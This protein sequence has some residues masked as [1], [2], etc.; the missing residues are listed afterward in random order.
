MNPSLLAQNAYA[1]RVAP[2][3]T[4][5]GVE[6]DAF[7]KITSALKSAAD[8]TQKVAALHHNRSLWALLAAD[9]ADPENALPDPLRAQIF[10]LA[11]FTNQ[12]TRKVLQKEAQV[13]VLIE[14]NTAMMRGLRQQPGVS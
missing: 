11:E 14:V 6:Y 7:A 10:Y 4:Y 3:R 1:P 9:V 8:F 2:I 13:D 5:T 12:H